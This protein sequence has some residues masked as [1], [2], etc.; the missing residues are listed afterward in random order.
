M[1]KKEINSSR[2]PLYRDSG[3]ELYSAAETSGAFLEETRHER[4]PDH[5]IY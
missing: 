2:T 1:I 5:Y 3:F 4:D